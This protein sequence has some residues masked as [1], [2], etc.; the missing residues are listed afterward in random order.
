MVFLRKYASGTGADLYIPM[1]KRAVVDFAVSADWTP[2]AGDVKVSL[3]GAAAANIATLPVAVTMGNTAMWKF[4]FSNSELTCKYLSVTV[5]D[6][7]TKAVEDAMFVVETYGHASAL[8]PFD[9]ATAVQ[10]VDVTKWNGT[11]IPGVDTA[12]YPKVT[13]KD[14]TGTG[15]IDTNAG[16]VSATIAAGDIA[17]NAITAAAIAD[18]AIDAPTF[19]TGAINASAIAADAI[20]DAKVAA[21]VTIAS[22]TGA[23]GSVTGSVGSVGA[24]GISNSSF[25]AGAIDNAAIAP[26]AIG[27]SE[28]ATSAVTEIVDALLA[29]VLDVTQTGDTVEGA[30]VAAR[31]QGFGK[32]V[33]S[34]TTLTLYAA[35]GSTIVKTL[36]F[37]SATNP[38]S[39]T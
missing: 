4:V 21:D 8:H 12:G 36:T 30:L 19:A 18:G 1:V 39:R 31:A 5:A 22:V 7:A 38:T 29:T 27:S 16:K 35:D 33:W 14:G 34:G 2:A 9:L 13:V 6:S 37:N 28:L 23:V 25:A 10:T 32:W 3:D 11:S 17:N 15:E 24:G 20:T 26:D